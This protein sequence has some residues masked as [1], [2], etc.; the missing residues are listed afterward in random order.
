MK[1]IILSTLFLVILEFGFYILNRIFN[2]YRTFKYYTPLTYALVAIGVIG[3]V[4]MIAL[5]CLKKIKTSSAIYYG[6][7]FAIVLITGLFVK[8]FYLLPFGFANLFLM[9]R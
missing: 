7:I 9:R 4:V 1:K 8:F 5:A 2:N 6:V 3:L